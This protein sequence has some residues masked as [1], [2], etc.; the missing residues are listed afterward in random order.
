MDHRPENENDFEQ[1]DE[2]IPKE[3]VKSFFSFISQED[4]LDDFIFEWDSMPEHYE[5][6][7]KDCSL[8]K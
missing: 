2:S 6:K 1:C 3:I 5:L 8:T 7:D 4:N